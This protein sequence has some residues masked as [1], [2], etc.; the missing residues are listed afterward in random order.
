[1]AQ[2]TDKINFD[3]G[4]EYAIP[5]E[6]RPPGGVSIRKD[7]QTGADVFMYKRRPGVYYSG[8]GTEV[9]IAMAKRAGF[10]VDR[11]LATREKELKKA[12]F[13]RNWLNE[14]RHSEVKTIVEYNGYRLDQHPQTGY[15]VVHIESGDVMTKNHRAQTEQE[16]RDWLEGF[17]GPPPAENIAEKVT[18]GDVSRASEPGVGRANRRSRQD[19]K[20]SGDVRSAGN[21]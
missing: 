21:P 1:M 8:H 17:A 14:N 13:E 12:E 6:R 7:P 11:H 9:A 16:G 10:D 2:V 15:Y 4:I 18:D 20:P 3:D 5:A 19:A